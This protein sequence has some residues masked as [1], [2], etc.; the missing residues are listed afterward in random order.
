MAGI[1]YSMLRELQSELLPLKPKPDLIQ[2]GSM[3][4]FLKSFNELRTTKPTDTPSTLFGIPVRVNKT[5]PEH[6]VVMLVDGRVA[7]IINLNEARHAA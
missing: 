6:M 7:H 3:E 1:T 5:L 4:Q 2:V